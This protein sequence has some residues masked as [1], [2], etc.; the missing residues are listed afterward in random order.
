[1]VLCLHWRVVLWRVV[2]W[3][4][5]GLYLNLGTLVV[6][7]APKPSIFI[8]NLSWK[9]TRPH[10]GCKIHMSQNWNSKPFLCTLQTRS[11]TGSVLRYMTPMRVVRWLVG[12]FFPS[13]SGA[14]LGGHDAKAAPSSPLTI[15]YWRKSKKTTYFSTT[16]LSVTFTW[17]TTHPMRRSL[18]T[19]NA[20]SK[21]T[22]FHPGTPLH[23]CGK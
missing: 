18:A 12:C 15:A 14:R 13:A 21:C 22:D 3:A 20:P 11:K 4:A 19:G 6:E 8:Y 7:V 17:H 2:I 5:E 9:K 1:M 16:P 23:G 10:K